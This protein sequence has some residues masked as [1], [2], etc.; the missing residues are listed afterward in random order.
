MEYLYQ[1]ESNEVKSSGLLTQESRT[2]SGGDLHNYLEEL[3][4]YEDLLAKGKIIWK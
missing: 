4:N 1:K 3:E 2:L